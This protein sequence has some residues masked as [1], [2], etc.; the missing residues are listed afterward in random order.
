[1]AVGPASA[2][3]PTPNVPEYVARPALGKHLV[4]AIG[5]RV[6]HARRE[7]PQHYPDD[8]LVR[9][10]RVLAWVPDVPAFG[11]RI[12]DAHDTA[13]HPAPHPVSVRETSTH[14]ELDNGRLRV[15]ASRDGLTVIDGD[16]RLKNVLGLETVPDAGDSYTPSLRGAP[17]SL[18]LH[19][20]RIGARGP[21]RG[22]VVLDWRWRLGRERLRVRTEIIL[23]AGASVV[24][25]DVRGWN[26]RRD[27]RL[28]LVWHTDVRAARSTADAAFGP[29]ERTPI[30]A[31]PDATPFE[32]PPATMPLHRWLSAHDATRGVALISDGLAEGEAGDARLA[33]TLLRAIGQLSKPDLPE[34]PGHAGWPC[35]IP[36][37]QVQGPFAARVGLYL[38]GAWSDETLLEIEDAADAL[39]LPLTGESWR[40]LHGTSRVL[41]GPSL[42]GEGLVASAVHVRED[43]QAIVLRAVNLTSHATT[44]RWTLP[45][46][47]TW[48]FRR[49]RLDGTPLDDWTSTDAVVEFEAGARAVVTVEVRRAGSSTTS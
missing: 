16:R 43:G 26:G 31:P 8:D 14:I 25:C 40:D 1:M 38:H 4:Q 42:A 37:A 13:A 36:A 41:A 12:L 21:L 44:G 49:C 34:R 11:V 28:Q 2:G 23:D 47:A 30:V 39:L 15:L 5:A 18:R 35:D 20:V 10:H 33:V 27:H 7:S 17:E 46:R 9:E 45:T 24:R 32:V 6:R 29:V 22:S 48:Q 3:I 19:A